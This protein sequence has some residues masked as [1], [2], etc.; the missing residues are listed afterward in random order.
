MLVIDGIQN[1]SMAHGLV[2]IQV[3]QVGADGQSKGVE[4]IA[5]PASQFGNVVQAL[6]QAGHNLRQ[7]LE[8]QQQDKQQSQPA[9]DAP[10]ADPAAEAENFDFSNN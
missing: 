8:E 5:I 3:A 10:A 2:R 4:T 6:N 1:V 9:A 7:R